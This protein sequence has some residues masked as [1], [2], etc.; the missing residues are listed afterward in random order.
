VKRIS[1]SVS[2]FYISNKEMRKGVYLY[3]MGVLVP[4]AEL[5]GLIQS[6]PPSGKIFT[7]PLA[8]KPATGPFHAAMVPSF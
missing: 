4:R 6:H 7:P 5:V 3:E 8:W 2:T 1:F